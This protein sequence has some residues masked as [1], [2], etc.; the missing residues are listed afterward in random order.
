[1]GR[2][3]SHV[4]DSGSAAGKT[5]LHATAVAVDGRAVLL[6]GPSGAGKSGLALELMAL[7]AALVADDGVILSRSSDGVLHASP[8]DA[9]RGLIEARGV[10]LLRAAP[11]DRATVALA[12]DL[13]TLE[14]DRLPPWRTTEILGVAVPLLH[15][16]ESP[17]FPAA[18]RLYLSCGRRE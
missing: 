13:G 15:K 5:L 16:V 17:H 14:T 2:G 10:G 8:P 1:M 3:P 18:I 4:A 11:L 9:T 12:V 6:L 7:G